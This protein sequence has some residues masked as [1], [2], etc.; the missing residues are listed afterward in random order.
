MPAAHVCPRRPARHVAARLRYYV[1]G[2]AR[3][4]HFKLGLAN[5]ICGLLPVFGSGA[6]RSRLYRRVG[7]DVATSA[8]IMGN[9]E[10]LAG[11]GHGF[12]DKLHIAEGAVIG[13]HVTI[14][15]D[16]HV[17]ICRNVSVGPFVLIYTA[18]HPLGPGSNRRLSTTVAKPVVIGEGSWIG[19]GAMLLP[20]V[21]VGQGSVVAAG[22]VVSET[23]PPNVYVEG[24][25]A[26]VIRQLPWGDR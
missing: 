24:N 10:L 2:A 5:W 26:R 15:L 17:T 4:V 11:S 23:V 19:L 12:Y 7:F 18:T 9:L 14:N 13:N 3:Q 20:G 1:G 6:L 8:F 25:P 16:E 21:C 22:S